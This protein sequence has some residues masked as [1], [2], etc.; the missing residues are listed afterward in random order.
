[1]LNISQNKLSD[2]GISFLLQP[3][4]KA[5]LFTIKLEEAEKKLK[6]AEAKDNFSEIPSTPKSGDD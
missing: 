6:E 5:R 2:L 1:M 3:L 4:I